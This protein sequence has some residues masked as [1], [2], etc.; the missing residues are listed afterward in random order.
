MCDVTYVNFIGNNNTV[1]VSRSALTSVRSLGGSNDVRRL[2]TLK[3]LS[4]YLFHLLLH[5]KISAFCP[6]RVLTCCTVHEFY[7]KYPIF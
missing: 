2:L 5:V 3:Q 4:C 6:P 7:N 1:F